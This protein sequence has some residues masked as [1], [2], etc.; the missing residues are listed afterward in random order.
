MRTVLLIEDSQT[1]RMLLAHWLQEEGW[2]VLEAE[3]GELGLS[4]ARQHRPDVIICD[5]L[6][7]RCNGYQ[8]CRSIRS[9]ADWARQPK[10][11]VTT[12]S[13]YAADRL[14]ALEAGADY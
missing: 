12:S 6:M 1:S 10:I 2:H 7:P 8:V 14:N 3:D 5:L 4:M 9:D 11:V 13:D